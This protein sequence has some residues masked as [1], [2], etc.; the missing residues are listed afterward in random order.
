MMARSTRCSNQRPDTLMQDRSP[1]TQRSSLAT[2]GRTI[3][4]VSA[5]EILAHPGTSDVGYKQ[6]YKLV[7]KT[8]WN[9]TECKEVV[10][11]PYGHKPGQPKRTLPVWLYGELNRARNDFLHGNPITDSRLI[12]PPG[13]QPLHLYAAPLFRMALAAFLDLKMDMK[14]PKEGETEY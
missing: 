10:Y 6:V 4:W 14:P 13:K 9:L 2:H 3:H 8:T 12:V 11:E 5:F 7:E 1:P